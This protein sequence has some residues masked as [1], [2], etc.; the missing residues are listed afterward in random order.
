MGKTPKE[1]HGNERRRPYNYPRNAQA[2]TRNSGTESRNYSYPSGNVPRRIPVY[3]IHQGISGPVPNQPYRF[4]ADRGYGGRLRGVNKPLKPILSRQRRPDLRS[5]RVLS[6]LRKKSTTNKMQSQPEGQELLQDKHEGTTCQAEGTNSE[7]IIKNGPENCSSHEDMKDEVVGKKLLSSSLLSKNLKVRIY[8]TVILPV[9]LYGCETWTLTLREEHRLRVFENKVLR[10]I[11][12]AKRDEVTGE[13]RKLHNTEL[14]A[15]YSSPDIIR[16]IKSRRLRWAGHVACMGESR[17]AYR[18]LV[19]RPEG[20]RPLGRPRC[21]WEDNIK[22]DLREVGYD[23]REWINLAQDRD[24]WRAYV[25]SLQIENGT[26]E[27]TDKNPDSY[28]TSGVNDKMAIKDEPEKVQTKSKPSKEKKTKKSPNSAKA[29]SKGKSPKSKKEQKDVEEEAG[30]ENKEKEKEKQNKKLEVEARNRESASPERQSSAKTV[31]VTPPPP[32]ATEPDANDSV[33]E[34]LNQ[35]QSKSSSDDAPS[36]NEEEIPVK[37][38]DTH[39]VKD[40]PRRSTRLTMLQSLP[41]SKIPE[42]PDSSS[43]IVL[44]SDN[45]ISVMPQSSAKP[46]NLDS[47]SVIVLDSDNSVSVTPQSSA[48]PKIPENPDS[49]S[50]IVLDS[51]D[52][53]SVMGT[54]RTSQDRSFAQ[55]L[56]SLSGRPSLRSLPAYN[57]SFNR[58]C[59]TGS[60]SVRSTISSKSGT[61]TGNDSESDSHDNKS[62]PSKSGL[63]GLFRTS[64]NASFQDSATDNE[65][66][67]NRSVADDSGNDSEATTEP[68]FEASSNIS[69][70]KR[71][72]R[73][74]GLLEEVEQEKKRPRAEGLDQRNNANTSSKLMSIMSS[75]MHLFAS[76]IRSDKG[77]SSTPVQMLKS[78][79]MDE[80]MSMQQDNVSEIQYDDD[81]P[82]NFNEKASL[83]DVSSKVD[84][85][86]VAPRR[87]CSIM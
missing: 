39:S 15:L 50:V 87:W 46:E 2:Q 41:K 79:V 62:L 65:E 5:K 64:Q 9:V 75:P 49:S 61:T 24:Q 51:D 52:S 44:D 83:A 63:W 66:S 8:K 27:I 42:N 14:H 36:T 76:K 19:G 4:G 72:S 58:P 70:G 81:N 80:D 38:V 48:K 37:L 16:K 85:Q 3:N 25:R 86:E 28:E 60:A 33:G 71:K 68:A 67:T 13:W 56:R 78:S 17:N 18:V 55:S 32:R 10:K 22:M 77:K 7:R 82:N 59:T 47:S 11:F 45:G 21:R 26:P 34:V 30:T 57:R 1:K 40:S 6:P 84:E 69:F 12:G 74:A 35:D 54:R 23:D 73:D 20:K 43:V 29:S 53:I 31:N